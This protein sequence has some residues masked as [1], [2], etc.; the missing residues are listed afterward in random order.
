[1]PPATFLLPGYDSGH[2]NT[3][4]QGKKPQASFTSPLNLKGIVDPAW[5]QEIPKQA[6]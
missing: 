2:H 3:L 6:Q 5:T 1:M 4:S